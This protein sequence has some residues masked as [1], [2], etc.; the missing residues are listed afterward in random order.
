[1]NGDGDND[2]DYM[3]ERVLSPPV[4][5]LPEGCES[6]EEKPQRLPVPAIPFPRENIDELRQVPG[7]MAEVPKYI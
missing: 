7:S 3:N 1:M 2:Y 5:E 6:Y 4:I